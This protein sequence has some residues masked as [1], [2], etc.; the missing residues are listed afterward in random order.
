MKASVITIGDEILTGQTID[1]N[2]A[3]IATRLNEIGISLEEIVSVSDKKEAILNTVERLRKSVS[4][5]IITGGLGPTNDDITKKVLT[6]YAEDKLVIYPAILAKIEAFFASINRPFLESNRQ[7]AML[8][9]KATIIEN[10]LG[11]ASGM[12]FSVGET[13]IISLPGVPYEMKGLV[14]KLLPIFKERFSLADFYHQTINFQGIGESMLADE[15]KDMEEVCRNNSVSVAYLPSPGIVRL[16]LTGKIENRDFIQLQLAWLEHKF[17]KYI[18]GR[19][20]QT[21]Q[22]VIGGILRSQSAT[23]GT[24]ES[25]TGGALA[26]RI[27]TVPGSSD[28][29]KGSI[30][31]YANELK[32]KLVHVSN[33]TLEDHGAVSRQTVEE[34]AHHG[35]SQLKT[36]Y[37]IATSGIAGPDGGSDEKPV[38]TVWIAVATPA[39]VHSKL[40]HFK[41]NRE[42]NI[43]LSVVNA[44][45]FL[46]RELL[47]LD[48]PNL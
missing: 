13:H 6:D 45:N 25:C 26:A 7:Q 19:E 34:M 48:S 32:V 15:I 37:C 40:F 5:I 1:S 33:S 35:R 31:S 27:V 8:P 42:R 36:D 24:V 23:L 18:Y 10:E 14:D 9:E 30:I 43:E 47:Q 2:S 41:H 3:W 4:L 39:G 12:W 16:R 29:F 38:G 17:P 44:L 20:N 46:R 11:T 22:E 28:Y 21:L